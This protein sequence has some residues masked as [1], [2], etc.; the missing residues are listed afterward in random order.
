M[1]LSTPGFANSRIRAPPHV[2]PRSPGSR[3]GLWRGPNEDFYLKKSSKQKSYGASTHDNRS[4]PQGGFLGKCAPGST[5]S[6]GPESTSICGDVG[7]VDPQSRSV[8]ATRGWPARWPAAAGQGGG[9]VNRSRPVVGSARSPQGW[10]LSESTCGRL[11]EVAPGS[12]LI[13]VDLRSSQRGVALGS[14]LIGVDL[15]TVHNNGFAGWSPSVR[16]PEVFG[17][18]C[19]TLVCD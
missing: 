13:G 3:P 4:R 18:P 8:A 7:E 9:Q 12:A 16:P 1:E 17:V 11:S 15:N 6:C 2:K 19:S 5:R 14:T 10:L